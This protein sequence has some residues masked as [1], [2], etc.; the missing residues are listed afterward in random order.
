MTNPSPDHRRHARRYPRVAL[1][2]ATMA[3]TV[4][5]WATGIAR[6]RPVV[7]PPAAIPPEAPPAGGGPGAAG[8]QAVQ[9]VL[10]WERTYAG[11]TF[12]ESSPVEANVSEPAIVVGALDGNVYGLDSVTGADLPGWPVATGHPINSSPAAADMYGTGAD[13]VV[14][15]SGWADSGRCA[16]GG[17]FVIDPS[18]AVRW[19]RA[20]VDPLCRTLAFHSSPAVGDITGSGVADVTVGALGLQSWSWDANGQLNAGWPFY[21]D[22]TV[23]AT[24][25]LADLNGDGTTEVVMGGDASP[26]GVFRPNHRGGVVRAVRGDGRLLWRFATNEIVRSS[27][28]VGALGG[29]QGQSIV[30]GTG[31]YWVNQPGG[32]SDYDRV[33]A[34]DTSGRLRWTRHLG[35]QTLGAPALADVAGTGERDV[36]IGTADGPAGGRVWVLGP[37]GD[38]LPHWDGVPSG[39]GV[40]IGAVSTADLNGDGAQDVLVPTGSGVFVLDGRTAQPM[41]SI[42]A[43]HAA[44]QSTPVVTADPGGA[45]GIT[46]AGTEPGGV[47]V[48]QHWVMPPSSG[49]QLGSRGWPT[50]HHD[51]RRTGNANPPPLAQRQCLGVGIA[52]YWEAAA[53]GGV[54]GW[55]GAGFHGRPAPSGLAA[56]VVAMASSPTGQGY[57][58]AAADGGVFAFGD[59]P[60]LGSAHGASLRA[61][62]VG[63]ARTPDGRGYW[64]VA[65]DGGVFA[66]GDAPFEGGG[67]RVSLPFRIAAILATP[68]G[69][70][71][72]LVGDEGSVLTYGDAQ[73]FG[74]TGNIPLRSPIV[75][76]AA[77]PSGQGYWLVA[78]DGGVFTYGDAP[79]LGSTGAVRLRQP[80]V[81]MAATAAGRG[82]WLAAADGGVFAFGD[83]HFVGSTSGL[84]LNSPVRAIAAPAG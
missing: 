30:F 32:A 44:F 7:L 28:A 51:G 11:V 81:G 52:G 48:I 55:C 16:G 68:S 73:F 62:I 4:V 46:V 6:E 59:A 21:T 29:H 3:A 72:W 8:G 80:I 67:G 17:V 9:P 31:N 42:D 71:Y 76:A 33:S 14:V 47:G 18:G 37:G 22:D 49:A 50:F 12:R 1:F 57:W 43:G 39:G 10:A 77:T 65:A 5:V 69:R 53:D 56:P 41:F 24:P 84:H 26:G 38:P 58:E 70:G 60:Y 61:P 13:E 54:F 74:S 82:Y 75:A 64:L 2:T 15:A 27:P 20:G 23:F 25:A 36:V 34:L 66:F 45:V 40:V 63:M 78:A 19:V 83:A 35:G 79:F